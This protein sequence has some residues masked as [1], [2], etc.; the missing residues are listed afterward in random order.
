MSLAS[1]GTR[2]TFAHGSDTPRSY[3]IEQR[4]KEAAVDA[5]AAA[6]AERRLVAGEEEHQV[7]DLLRAADPAQRVQASPGGDGGLRL[8]AA[9]HVG[10][11]F[12]HR[13]P[14]RAGRDAGT[15]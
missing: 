2:T 6:G 4:R 10:G 11:V 12:Q 7:G 8:F 13:G 9:E 5:V 1:S 14:D 15:A 3:S